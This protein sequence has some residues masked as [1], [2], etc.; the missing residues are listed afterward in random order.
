MPEADSVDEAPAR[1]EAL[2]APEALVVEAFERLDKWRG[3]ERNIGQHLVC[4]ENIKRAKYSGFPSSLELA[5]QA[6]LTQQEAAALFG[7]STGDFRFVNQVARGAPEAVFDDYPQGQKAT[8]RLSRAEV[9]PYVAM[10]STALR[11]LP[12]ECPQRL[13]RGHRRPLSTDLA[14]IVTLDGFASFAQDRDEALKFVKQANAG[15]SSQRTVLVVESH[16]SGR[17]ISRFSARR[18]EAEVLFPLGCRFR[19]VEPPPEAADQDAGAVE[20]ALA[21][22]RTAL[23]DATIDVVHLQEE[24]PEEGP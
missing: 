7:W 8:C 6:G 21:E 11:K 18:Q 1:I 9:E 24:L 13:W 4:K 16:H 15:T 17:S 5:E 12:A 20:A 23:P 22:L 19:V 10:V 2:G 14:A 3:C